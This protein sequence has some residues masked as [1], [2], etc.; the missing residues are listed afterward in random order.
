MSVSP[1]VETLPA[2]RLPRRLR[3]LHPSR[4]PDARGQNTLHCWWIGDGTFE[5]GKIADRLLLRLDPDRPAKHGFVEPDQKM[6]T[7]DFRS[8]L[9]AMCDQ[10][11]KWVE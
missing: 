1:S 8:A 9:A 5:A 6:S 3:D 7:A 4:F 2:H 11:H 10:W